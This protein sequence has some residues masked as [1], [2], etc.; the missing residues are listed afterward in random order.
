M[1]TMNDDNAQVADA[2][3]RLS[4]AMEQLQGRY[5]AIE[6]S[7]RR[8]RIAFIIVLVLFGGAMYK[9][10]T[11]IA[12]QLGAFPQIISQLVPRLK[13][14]T[15]DPDEAAAERQRLMAALAP[16]RRALVERFEE[17]QKWVSDYIAASQDFDPGATIALFLS[18]MANSVKVMPDLYHEVRAMTEEV[19]QTIQRALDD[20]TSG[21]DVRSSIMRCYRDMCRLASHHGIADE[22]HLTPREFERLVGAKLPIADDKLRELILIFE[23]ARYSD[24]D[25]SDEMRER[26]LGALGGIRDDLSV[27]AEEAEGVGT[28]ANG[29]PSGSQGGE[30]SAQ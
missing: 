20:M 2:L 22:E 18:D 17:N 14:A 15:I 30:V 1:P 5:D 8:M 29:P 7:N 16:E 26:A 10:I 6:R 24:H 23:E 27:D 13:S 28:D 25:L 9:A 12:E 19:G 21:T 4:N 3:N 11:P